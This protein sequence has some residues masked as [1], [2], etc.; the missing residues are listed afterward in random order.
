MSNERSLLGPLVARK[1]R[2]VW[3]KFQ[4]VIRLAGVMIVHGWLT[5]VVTAISCLWIAVGPNI[6]LRTSR[7]SL[8]VSQVLAF[9][10]ISLLS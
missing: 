2:C 5:G 9:R 6:A 3:S 1:A 4:G 7:R 8:S 10:C